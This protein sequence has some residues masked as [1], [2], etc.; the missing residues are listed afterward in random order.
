MAELATKRILVA[1]DLGPQSA[2]ALTW[3]RWF[4]MQFAASVDVLH[5]TKEGR[6][7]IDRQ[8][9][10]LAKE[11]L[12]DVPFAVSTQEGNAVEVIGSVARERRTGLVIIG[13]D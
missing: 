12:G 11:V 6:A 13:D 9:Q 1:V 7:Y 4:A 3:A 5:T 8:I 10:R 2:N